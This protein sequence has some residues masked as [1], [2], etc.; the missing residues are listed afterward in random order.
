MRCVNHPAS[1]TDF[2]CRYC[3]QPVCEKCDLS[4]DRNLHTCSKCLARSAVSDFGLEELAREEA[5]QVLQ[6]KSEQSK[7][8]TE[9]SKYAIVILAAIVVP[10]RLIAYFGANQD[11][12]LSELTEGKDIVNECIYR[13]LEASD[14]IQSGERPGS[15]ATCASS[16]MPLLV[17]QAG[18]E[19]TV[20]VQDPQTYGYSVMR[21]SRANPIP[22]L[23]E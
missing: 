21:V 7:S 12:L 15:G 13:L 2:W 3:R 19:L 22:L 10:W 9:K 23:I 6:D 16:D 11:S 1:E 5:L 18:D 20:E 4:Q 14:K 8:R 17:V